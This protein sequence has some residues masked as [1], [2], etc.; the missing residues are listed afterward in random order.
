MAK[1]ESVPLTRAL[2]KAAAIAA[3]VLLGPVAAARAEP[4]FDPEPPM[5]WAQAL[6]SDLVVVATYESHEEKTLRLRVE[7]VLRGASSKAGDV[8][9]VGLEHRYVLVDDPQRVYALGSRSKREEAKGPWLCY[10]EQESNPGD[11]VPTALLP[12]VRSPAIYFLPTA[13]A[14]TLRRL[15]QVQGPWLADGWDA[16]LSGRKA[17]VTWRIAQATDA[18]VWSRAI[19]ELAVSRAPDAIETLFHW[20]LPIARADGWQRWAEPSGEGA[21]A[22]IGDRGGDVYDRAMELLDRGAAADPYRLTTLC[23]LVNPGRATRDL[24]ARTS[25]AHGRIRHAAAAALGDVGTS[26][27][28]EP[29]LRFVEAAA[30]ND[31]QDAP[32]N[33]AVEGLARALRLN[34]H[35]DNRRTMTEVDRLRAIAAPRLAAIAAGERSYVQQEVSS[36]LYDKAMNR[37]PTSRPTLDDVRRAVDTQRAGHGDNAES[38]V[39]R[40]VEAMARAPSPEYVP[41]LVE[42]LAV[43][44]PREEFTY[45]LREVMKR[46]AM[47]FRLA[48]RAACQ[49]AGLLE[50]GDKRLQSSGADDSR[51]GLVPPSHGNALVEWWRSHRAVL[52]RWPAPPQETV[53]DL[54]HLLEQELARKHVPHAEAIRALASFDPAAANVIFHQAFAAGPPSASARWEQDAWTSLVAEAVRRGKT[55]LLPE[56]ASRVRAQTAVEEAAGNVPSAPLLLLDTENPDAL[57]EF[58][59]FLDAMSPTSERRGRTTTNWEYERLLQALFLHHA[60]EF[61]PRVAALLA[62]DDASVRGRGEDILSQTLCWQIAG[63]G[64]TRDVAARRGPRLDTARPL[65]ARLATAR[66]DVEARV[67]FL[68]ARGVSLGGEPGASWIPALRTAASDPEPSVWQNAIRLLEVVAGDVGV[69][70]ELDRLRAPDRPQA[71]DGWLADRGLLAPAK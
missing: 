48:M 66:S 5:T 63:F 25:A 12:S 39:S 37:D 53:S 58:L 56:L 9:A 46:H 45:S 13:G 7:R 68:R 59:R 19:E 52:A 31:A 67:I 54:R 61:F 47:L 10:L 3:A 6:S 4:D 8:I 14:P 11:L 27:V 29:L 43:R 38:P 57:A 28:L 20:T 51:A 16:T 55:D 23:A 44:G 22:A 17:D 30:R 62:A 60:A 41:I 21:L 1:F 36:L 50:R 69:V 15:G 18:G 49:T 40:I 34:D 42:A 35:W 33:G 71:I 65:L 64:W 26:E 32:V 24:L 2:A 70:E